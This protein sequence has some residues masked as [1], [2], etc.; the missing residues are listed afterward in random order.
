MSTRIAAFS[1]EIPRVIPR[2]L[3]NNYAQ[4]A[5]NTKLENGA[6]LPVRRA[7]FVTRMPI[8]CKTIFK[9]G[10]EWLGWE[11]V[12]RVVPAPVAEDRI[13]V[14]GDGKPKVISGGITYDLAITRPASK[15]TTALV[16]G[17]VDP[18]KD[19]QSTILYTYTWLTDLDEESEPAPLSDGLLWSPGLDVRLTGFSPPPNGRGVNRMRIYRSQTSQLGQTNLYFIAERAAGTGA[20]I[21]VVANNPIQE[22]ITSTEYTSPPDDLQ[23]LTSLPNGMMAAFVGKKLYFCEPYKPHAWPESYVLTCD[24]EIVG[25]G[26]FGTSVAIMTKGCP[27]IAQGTAPENM[28]MDRVRVNLPCV[29]ALSIVDLGYSV[30]YASP[31]G[32]VTISQNGAVV[33]SEG[34]MTPDQWRQMQPESF[35]AGQFSGRYMASYAFSDADNIERR[36]IITF[37]LTGSQPFITRGSDAASAMFFEIGTGVLYLLRDGRDVFEWDAMSEPFGEMYWRSKLFVSPSLYNVGAVLIDGESA[38]SDA[39][40]KARAAKNAAIRA[41]NRARID[42][43]NSD[44][45][46]GDAALG[47]VTFAGSLI[48]PVEDEDPAFSCSIYGDG[49][50][51]RTIY[52]LNRIERLPAKRLYTTLE[53]EIRGN[54]QITGIT[55]AATPEEIAGG[56]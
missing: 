39:Q 19:L 3:D 34:L 26:V 42:A 37:D 54:T 36:G 24:Y 30:A 28:Q 13:Y 53:I 14:T 16:D 15:L 51:L 6:L 12:V 52:E 21:D 50:L 5:Q 45:A 44:G 22:V 46:L 48:E 17:S 43:D 33:E 49:K 11:G 56:G 35:I 25:L 7:R 23:G 31:R 41:R 1:G 20:F 40:L 8:D 2:L 4:V 38:I 32:L 9:N 10:D 55:V 18:D 27:Y 29:T 47:V